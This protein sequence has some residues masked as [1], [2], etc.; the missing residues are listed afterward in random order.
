MVSRSLA[1]GIPFELRSFAAKA[2]AEDRE[3]RYVSAAALGDDLGR[4]LARQGCRRPTSVI[5]S[6]QRALTCLCRSWHAR[7]YVVR[8]AKSGGSGDCG[9]EMVS[10][11]CFCCFLTVYGRE[12]G[13]QVVVKFTSRT[14][15]WVSFIDILY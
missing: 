9:R 1:F 4:W 11:C 14:R 5:P 8:S 2:M 13:A 7:T 3:Q 6:S 15:K 10:G 12:N